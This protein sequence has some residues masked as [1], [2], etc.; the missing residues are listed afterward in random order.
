MPFFCAEVGIARPGTAVLA[1]DYGLGVNP[2]ATLALLPQAPESSESL[3]A[4]DMGYRTREA[5][6]PGLVQYPPILM[7]GFSIDRRLNLDP[8]RSAVAAAWGAL[9]FYN[10]DGRFNGLVTA[11]NCESRDVRVRWGT[12]S[13]DAARGY[14]VDPAYADLLLAFGGIAG[15][16][17][18]QR[19]TLRVPVRDG[20]AWLERPIQTK[21]Y[22]GAGSYNG[23]AAIA[24][25]AVPMTRGGTA[26]KPVRNVPLKLID[27]VNK[28]YQYNDA[29]GTI[30]TLYDAGVTGYTNIGNTSNLYAGVAPVAGEYRTDNSRG[31]IQ[32][33]FNPTGTL[34]ADVT[35]QFPSA[36][37]ITTGALIARY[38]LTEDATVPTAYVNTSAFATA[39]SAY[40]YV[41]GIHVADGAMTAVD[42]VDFI[43][44][45][46]GARLIPSRAGALTPI[47]LVAPD[48]GA[49][50]VATY[51]RDHLIDIQPIALPAAID[52]PPWR[53]Q[54]GFEKNWTKQTSGI[55]AGASDAQ[56]QFA[57]TDG[58]TVTWS[59]SALLL[60][61]VRPNDPPVFGGALLTEADAQAV[62]NRLG[63]FYGTRRRAYDCTLPVRLGLAR[64][65]G[66]TATLAFALADLGVGK[67]ALLYGERF[68]PGDGTISYQVF[69]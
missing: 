40:P 52:P 28:I 12:K 36:G 13:Y 5:D 3:Y 26:P 23:D 21:R 67:P 22:S 51:T 53:L 37:A 42:A 19:T 17:T 65:I 57:P 27:R 44:T 69:V 54:M 24:G 15:A 43:L 16:W 60:T 39:D 62:V 31:L 66:E 18:L 64:D 11:Y 25:H 48:P 59:D 29:A 63:A 1:L 50:T 14:D 30:V 2:P 32:I 41:A 7:R 56:R 55:L 20:S 35:G 33:G 61:Y 6:A 8:G 49:P 38:L 46:M 10:G 47:M 34:T 58:K 68:R 4:S 45:S 9:E